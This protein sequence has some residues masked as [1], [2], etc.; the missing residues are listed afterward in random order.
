MI[1]ILNKKWHGT[2]VLLLP[3]VTNKIKAGKCSQGTVNF[4]DNG[5]M[6]F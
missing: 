4:S 2:F 6:L 5:T 1:S 3:S